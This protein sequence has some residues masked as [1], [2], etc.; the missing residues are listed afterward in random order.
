[1]RITFTV[2]FW[3]TLISLY[4]QTSNEFVKLK[5]HDPL[6]ILLNDLKSKSNYPPSNEDEWKKGSKVKEA[7]FNEKY[8]MAIQNYKEHFGDSWSYGSATFHALKSASK[9]DSIDFFFR[10]YETCPSDVKSNLKFNQ[11]NAEIINRLDSQHI[12][13]SL[14]QSNNKSKLNKTLNEK[15]TL[16][17]I[18]DQSARNPTGKVILG[19]W[20]HDILEKD[21]LTHL[22]EQ[23]RNLPGLELSKSHLAQLS[24]IIVNIDSFHFNQVGY[25]AGRALN[26]A[27]LHG[28][29]SKVE[30][31]YPFIRNNF[32]P[33][34]IAYFVD[35]AMVERGEPQIFGS[36]GDS[37]KIR[38]K[39]TFYPIH[40]LD[41]VDKYRMKVG[42]D[43]L[44]IYAKGLGINYKEE[45]EFLRR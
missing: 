29:P 10:L 1:M 3:V 21:S 31:F 5:D 39:P 37:D 36:Q 14:E 22:I 8:T 18:E 19:E 25:L 17:F 44:E 24:E 15:L 35:K 42:L 43:P 23:A 9:I 34:I 41:M 33:S 16:I 12:L 11:W 45:I 7:Y 20:V 2:A 30:R 40:N 27:L 13:D 26:L 4:G 38:K 6:N 32:R 28:S